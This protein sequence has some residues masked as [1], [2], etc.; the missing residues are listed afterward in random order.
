MFRAVL[1]AGRFAGQAAGVC[2][3]QGRRPSQE[4]RY[5]I[6]EPCEDFPGLHF[7]GIYDGH[8]GPGAAQYCS[9]TLV[10]HFLASPQLKKGNIGAALD[11][12]FRQTEDEYLEISRQNNVRDG[13]TAVTAVIETETGKLTVAHVGD[14]R[15][16][17]C[18]KGEAIGLTEDHKPEKPKERLAITQRNGFI[19][20]VGCWRVMGVLAMSRAIGDLP[21][22]PYVSAEAEIGERQLNDSDEFIVLASDGLWDVFNNQQVVDIVKKASNPKQAAALLTK[23]A[24]LGGSMDNITVAVVMLPGY[25]PGS[26]QP[27]IQQPLEPSREWWV[28]WNAVRSAGSRIEHAPGHLR[29]HP[30]VTCC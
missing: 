27:Q 14:S 10:S 12:A 30:E 7:Y 23:A 6:R 21:L 8:G 2:S 20:H 26:L 13:T 15:A 24:Y 3:A 22:K 29:P 5:C 11:E 18:S 4:D 19:S 1:C 16:V 17:L 9:T 25:K 28:P